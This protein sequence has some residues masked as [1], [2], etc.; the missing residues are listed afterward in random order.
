MYRSRVPAALRT[1]SWQLSA[2]TL[3]QQVVSCLAP[4]PRGRSRAS[5]TARWRRRATVPTGYHCSRSTRR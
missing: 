1:A 2:H 4:S 5:I 3:P